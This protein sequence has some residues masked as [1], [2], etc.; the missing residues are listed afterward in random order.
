M[1]KRELVRLK[2]RL[3]LALC[4]LGRVRDPRL[5]LT[6][7]TLEEAFSNSDRP[8]AEEPPTLRYLTVAEI[9]VII[10][11]PTEGEGET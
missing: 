10:A 8:L 3:A 5:K 4:E 6:P 1:T 2:E 9:D 7:I 11:A